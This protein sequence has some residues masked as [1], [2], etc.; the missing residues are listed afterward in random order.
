MSKT[1]PSIHDVAKHAGVSTATVSHVINKTRFVTEETK[2]KVYKSVEE[3]G[4]SANVMGRILKTGRRG[5]IGFIVPDITNYY[6]ASIIQEAENVLEKSEYRLIVAN[7]NENEKR[8]FDNL[9][10]LTSG[11]VD[12]IILASTAVSAQAVRKQIP[13]NM[14]TVLIDRELEGNAWDTILIDNY[15]AMFK[16]VEALINRGHQKIGYIT[17]LSHLSTSKNR[18]RAYK[19]AMAANGLPVED[20]YIAY[21]DSAKSGMAAKHAKTLIDSGCTSLVVSNN[22]MSDEVLFFLNENGYHLG[23][24]F[25]L[26]GYNEDNRLNYGM[27]KM[28]VIRQPAIE[29]GRLA[30]NRILARIGEID[31]PQEKIQL[32]SATFVPYE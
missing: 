6:F 31:A 32:E 11:F 29:M 8:E 9:R 27:R 21:G 15:N 23:V 30:G 13:D 17:G 3:L 12:G 7:T 1:R 24:N 4:Y 20:G 16:S 14:P 5:I 18:L 2:A 25:D 28:Y 26:V 19:D 22:T 10:V